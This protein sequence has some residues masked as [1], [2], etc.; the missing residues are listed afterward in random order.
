MLTFVWVKRHRII[1][2]A[3]LCL[4]LAGCGSTASLRDGE[5]LL[6][7][8]KIVV[9]DATY[10]ASELSAYL[11]QKPN[12]TI[13]G[14]NPLLSVYNWG[15]QGETAFGRFLQKVGVPP[16]VY[17]PALV[18]ES[19]GSIESHLRY[20]GYYGSQIESDVQV[21]GR[22]V[23]VTYYVALGRRYRISTIDYEIPQYGTFAQ[24]FA[25]DLPN[26]TIA[27]GQY[28]S[29]A[30]LEAEAERAAQVLRNKGYYGFTK[31]FFSF[32]ADT[33]ASDGNAALKFAIRDHALGDDPSSAREH[34]KYTLGAVDISYPERLKIRSSLL[35]DLNNLRPGQLYKEKE[36]NTAY[37]RFSGLS[38]LSG[39][40][41]EMTPVS[42]DQVDCHI[43]L[44]SALLQGFKINLEGSFNATGLFGISPQF[45][46]YHKNLF[47]GGE[48]LNLGVKGNF[49]FNPKNADAFSTDVSIS[50]SLRVPYFIGL[51]SRLFTGPNVPKTDFSASFSYQNR[52]EYRRTVI[53]TG[54]TYNGRYKEH[55][56]WQLSPIRANVAR[57]F[58]VDPEFFL[59]LLA[60]NPLLLMA[61]MDHFDLGVGGTVFYTT[62]PSAIPTRP[63]HYVRISADLSGNLLGLFN[64]LM[65][66]NESG[67]HTI[68][69]TPYSQ[70]AKL[71]LNMGKV[72]RFGKDDRHA[73]AVHAMAG[74][75]H[76]YGNSTSPP[77]EQQF[78]SGGAM[79]MRGW[80]A[81]SLG[82]GTSQLISLFAI[83]TQI[84]EM[85]LEGNLEYRFPLVWKLEGALFADCGNIWDLPKSSSD[86][87][88]DMEDDSSAFHFNTLP[89]SLALDWG[90]GIRVNLDFIL[91]RIDSGIRLRDPARE[92]GKR[93]VGP[94]EWFNGNYAIHFG[95]GYPF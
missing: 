90:L 44:R 48:L 71:E 74:I 22:K 18:D 59:Q 6:R 4:G 35:E 81:R 76:A 10:P 66:I 42:E 21:K 2:F 32:E 51:P 87:S 94:Q 65:P 89:Q 1:F 33:L 23:Y 70:Y 27:T 8:N 19:I 47:H 16:V 11:Q 9:D 43:H 25:E 72:F 24:D 13:L 14:V 79:S 12:T 30:S 73:L 82:P 52:P 34:K 60:R 45:T 77:V 29:E 3:L 62:D 95:V 56:F 69:E 68:W 26:T 88:E 37:S 28:L 86:D 20:T 7:K 75:A 83:P 49:Q 5:Y 93:W 67:Q 50:S 31:I 40:N 54:L 15:G 61:Y 41:L 57:L 36:V 85:K 84:G 78:Y 46:Y 91:L 53:S 39:V 92:A 64:P 80:Q 38:M 58:D 17:N 63:Y 55:L